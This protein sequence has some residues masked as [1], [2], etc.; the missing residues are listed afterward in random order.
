[1]MC[2]RQCYVSLRVVLLSVSH[3]HATS[4]IY[5]REHGGIMI[6]ASKQYIGT[7]TGLQH[8]LLIVPIATES[9]NK[10]QQLVD[11]K[12]ILPH[13]AITCTLRTVHSTADVLLQ[14]Q[15]L[16]T[17]PFYVYD[18]DTRLREIRGP[19][20]LQALLFLAQLFATTAGAM[21][22]VLTGITGTESALKLLQSGRCSQSQ[23]L[24]TTAITVLHNI[25]KLSPIRQYYPAHLT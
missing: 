23:P 14:L 21:P 11:G 10:K 8:G 5:N 3:S 7:L 6:V 17:P 19:N 15:S 18:V 24:S 12:L 9:D 2:S 22:D 4:S 1:M 25:S 13:C 20:D 16:H